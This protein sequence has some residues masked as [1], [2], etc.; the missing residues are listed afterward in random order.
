MNVLVVT[1][2][3]GI[4]FDKFDKIG[5]EMKLIVVSRTI[6]VYYANISSFQLTLSSKLR[7]MHAYCVAY[8]D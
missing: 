5:N 8:L 2:H 3:L 4:D 7:Q 1:L 6:N